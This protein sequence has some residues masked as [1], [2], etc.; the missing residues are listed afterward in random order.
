MDRF[1]EAFR[2]FER[3]VDVDRI[4]SFRQLKLTFESWASQK[5]LNTYRQN[6]ALKVE[7]RRYGIPIRAEARPVAPRERGFVHVPERVAPSWRHE[8][9]TVKGKS[10]ERYRDLRSGRFIE[11]P[12]KKR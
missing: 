3:D 1:P 7:A 2:R 10:Q 9:V 11:N 6:E 4:V 8:T 12:S 5:W